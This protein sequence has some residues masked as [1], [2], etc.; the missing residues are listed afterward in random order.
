MLTKDA[1][2]ELAQAQAITA[3]NAVRAFSEREGFAALPDNFQLHDLEKHLPHRRRARGTMTTSSVPDFAAYVMAH[4]EEGAAAFV[5]QDKMTATA[6]LNL[7]RPSM[8]GQADNRAKLEPKRTAAYM[9]LR[10]TANGGALKQATVA[11]FLEDWP[12]QIQCFN[13]AG[14]ITAPKAI[15][16]VRKISID[17]MR[18]IESA[19][20][21]LSATRSAFESVQATSTEPLP[22]TIYFKTVAYHGLTERNFVLRLGVLTTGDKPMVTLRVVNQEQHDEEMAA[23]L[24]ALVR[25]ALQGELPVLV[26]A[27]AAAA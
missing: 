25:E 26:G 12:G 13:E 22:T 20:Q 3:A 14:S 5:E 10:A 23:E 9:A 15:A 24:A 17:A 1:I 4:K 18:K 8:P 27:Y 11:E 2:Q 16:A 7:G 19:E 6:I 21:Q